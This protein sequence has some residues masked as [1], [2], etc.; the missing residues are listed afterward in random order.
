MNIDISFDKDKLS[1][2]VEQ[3]MIFKD[4]V[5]GADDS[6][7]VQISQ[8][9]NNWSG[10]EHDKAKVD[11]DNI[12]NRMENIIEQTNSAFEVLSEVSAGFNTIKY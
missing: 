9:N 6:I 7:K 2:L 3:F 8:I 5:R 10:E 12:I 1:D 11:L 4:A